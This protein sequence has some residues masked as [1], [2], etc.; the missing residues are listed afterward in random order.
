MLSLPSLSNIKLAHKLNAAFGLVTV[1]VLIMVI[2]SYTGINALKGTFDQYR[3]TARQSLTVSGLE[4]SL[5]K[6]RIAALNYRTA[7]EDTDRD[8][9]FRA[10]DE[11]INSRDL[12]ERRIDDP[13]VK[14]QL[15]ALEEKAVAYRAAFEEATKLQ[16]SR[17]KLASQ[18]EA[19]VVKT[20]QNITA[21]MESAY[22]DND[23][24][25]AYLSG[26]L[27]ENF[28]LARLYVNKFLL[29]NLEEDYQR[30]LYEIDESR[31]AHEILL[32]ELNNPERR[33]L[34]MQVEEGLSSYER[35]F[36]Q[37]YEVISKRNAFYA[38][39]EALGPEIMNGYLG[40]FNAIEDL[41]TNTLGPQAQKEME[42]ISGNTLALGVVIT[43]LAASCAFFIGRVFS[44]NINLVTEQMGRLAKG[45]NRFEIKGTKRGDEIGKMAKALLVFQENAQEVERMEAEQKEIEAKAAEERR[46]AMLQLAD[47]FDS[48]VGGIVEA[49][50]KAAGEMQAM[51]TQLSSAVEETNSQ[52]STVASASEQTNANTQT[53]ASATE[54]LTASI[55]E[56][57][58]SLADTAQTAKICASS[59]RSSQEQLDTLQNAIGEIDSVIQAIND[60]AEQTNLLALN[61]TI[62]AARA[63]EAG[64]GFAVVASEV[65][66]LAGQT[67]KMTDEIAQKVAM[68]KGSAKS[69]IETINDILEQIETVD[70]KTANVAA[71]VEEQ[72]SSTS[73]ISR[74]IQEAARGSSEISRNIRGIQDAANDSAQSTNS[75][76][77]ASD[78]LAKQAEDLKKAVLGFL[79]EVRAA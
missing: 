51:S 22:N 33:Q 72:T 31:K 25:A 6:A 55:Q 59:A 57:S 46:K 4:E 26:A 50:N 75:L 14:E 15:F 10:I 42:Q 65:K 48:Q 77:G 17:D 44:S 13:D 2:F 24:V 3:D 78:G 30:A 34:A 69:T 29:E 28:M 45:D 56:I 52:S 1:L 68:I 58:R 11:I 23:P 43:L 18:M 71:A 9:V 67:H 54:E 7:N 62:E 27:Q 32:T 12:V 40:I 60:V 21:I 41:Q 36:G 8:S 5:M 73:E 20:R 76:K 39:T 38:E 35:E 66:A 53:V 74:N 63:G 79:K 61:A 37:I 47:D 19:D 64:K 70:S 16:Q 49:V